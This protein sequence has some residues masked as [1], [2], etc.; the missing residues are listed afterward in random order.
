MLQDKI[1]DF[2]AANFDIQ[3]LI[4]HDSF[5]EKLLLSVL[6]PDRS[7][8]VCRADRVR[9]YSRSILS[10]L[11]IDSQICLDVSVENIGRMALIHDLGLDFLLMSWP[12]S[13]YKNLIFDNSKGQANEFSNQAE[14]KQSMAVD[15][16]KNCSVALHALQAIGG[17]S[18]YSMNL[19][20]SE[21]QSI[22]LLT[23]LFP[24]LICYDDIFKEGFGSIE[25]RHKNAVNGVATAFGESMD[26]S[27][28][29]AFLLVQDEFKFIGLQSTS[30]NFQYF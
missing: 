6:F 15:L 17:A 18:K 21:E 22:R 12:H 29:G 30:S 16:S 19:K 2:D 28:F 25:K 3:K 14:I 4:K 11:N 7:S 1:N 26:S 8:A 20:E 5:F 23:A 10:A 24:M 27:L 13:N 9:Q